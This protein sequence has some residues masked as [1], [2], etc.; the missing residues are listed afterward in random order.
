MQAQG[1][2]NC[3]CAQEGRRKSPSGHCTPSVDIV[4]PS[5]HFADVDKKPHK[6]EEAQAAY[7]T[8][9]P[10]KAAPASNQTGGTHYATPE[11]VQKASEEVFKVH[12]KLFRKLAQ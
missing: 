5:A 7:P 2:E 3:S 12:E 10:A 8:S 9:K 11:Q 6:V 4:A 1:S